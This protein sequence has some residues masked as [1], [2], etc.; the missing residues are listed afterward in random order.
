MLRFAVVMIGAA[1][2]VVAV[3]ERL[4]AQTDAPER[5]AIFVSAGAGPGSYDCGCTSL[6][7]GVSMQVLFGGPVSP[8]ALVGLEVTGWFKEQRRA[9]Y[10]HLGM[11]LAAQL[12]PLEAMGLFVRGSFGLASLE[13]SG[14]T[15][16]LDSPNGGSGLGW[17]AGVGYDIGVLGHVAVTPY[18]LFNAGH[19]RDGVTHVHA[20]LAI[21]YR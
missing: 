10:R 14:D 3:P 4:N 11:S 18:A 12:Y 9:E 7:P 16:N 6:D 13:I 21:T 2:L 20:G 1:T 5:S 17:G 19:V 8:R 15:R